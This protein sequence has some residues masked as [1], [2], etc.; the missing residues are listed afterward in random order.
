MSGNQ[1][2][3]AVSV[4]ALALVQPQRV[5]ENAAQSVNDRVPRIDSVVMMVLIASHFCDLLCSIMVT[6][7]LIS[8][9]QLLLS[10]G[11]K[12]DQVIAGDTVVGKALPIPETRLDLNEFC[13]KHLNVFDADVH[14]KHIQ[15]IQGK[16][17]MQKRMAEWKQT[18]HSGN[19]VN[20]KP[21]MDHRESIGKIVIDKRLQRASSF[22]REYASVYR[23]M[24]ATSDGVF[25]D[26]SGTNKQWVYF[27]QHSFNL[28][29]MTLP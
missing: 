29:P 9:Q 4:S 8:F 28:G 1:F 22:Q 2:Q 24:N 23:A 6:G 15:P 26:N 7:F 25:E 19:I 10:R 3:N 17:G 13:V 18:V 11:Q 20:D 12:K 16:G 5:K 21:H 27:E 14:E